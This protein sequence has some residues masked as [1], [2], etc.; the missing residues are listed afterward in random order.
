MHSLPRDNLRRA[1]FARLTHESRTYPVDL[2]NIVSDALARVLGQETR[3]YR[4][5]FAGKHG[6]LFQG[7]LVPQRLDIT[8]AVCDNTTAHITCLA[9]RADLP[10]KELLGLPVEVQIVTDTG[11]LRRICVIVTEVR[12]G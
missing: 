11:D 10:I 7:A 4:L 5:R 3:P 2:S 8:E 1:T 9:T 12:Q 6:L